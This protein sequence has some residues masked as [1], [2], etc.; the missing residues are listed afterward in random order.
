LPQETLN[1]ICETKGIPCDRSDS[2]RLETAL[3]RT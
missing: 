1:L 3:V 2:L